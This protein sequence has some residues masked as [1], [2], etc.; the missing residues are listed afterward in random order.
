[1]IIKIEITFLFSLLLTFQFYSLL[2]LSLY[3]YMI[4]SM[5]FVHRYVCSDFAASLKNGIIF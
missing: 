1:M 4:K 3:I 2:L 5:Y